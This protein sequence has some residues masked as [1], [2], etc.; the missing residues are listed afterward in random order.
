VLDYQFALKYAESADGLHWQRHGEVALPCRIPGEDAVARPH[1]IREGGGYRM[2]YSRKKGPN[3]RL[4]YAESDDG[5]AWRR[6]DDQA[7]LQ[8]TPG[9]WDSDMVAYAFVFDHDGQRYMLYNGNGY[10]RTGFGL[11]V[12]E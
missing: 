10:G 4:G 5:R 3:Y 11:A 7:G 9:G 6:L 12:A 8:V 2:W 1:V